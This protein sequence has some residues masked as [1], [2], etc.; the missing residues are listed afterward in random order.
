VLYLVLIL[1]LIYYIYSIYLSLILIKG[2][3]YLMYIIK[4]QVNIILQLDIKTRAVH[5]RNDQYILTINKSQLGKVRT[6][7][8]SYMHP[9]MLYKLDTGGKV[10]F[11]YEKISDQI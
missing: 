6:L 7:I 3:H 8:E 10:G 5:D 11:N 1:C 9:S 4:R 2:L